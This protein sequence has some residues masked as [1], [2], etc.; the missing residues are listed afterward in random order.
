MHKC[1]AQGGTCRACGWVNTSKHVHCTCLI[2]HLVRRM[3][4]PSIHQHCP[5]HC[6]GPSCRDGNLAG[7]PGSPLTIDKYTTLCEL[8]IGTHPQPPPV[9]EAL[10]PSEGL[11][12]E[13]TITGTQEQSLELSSRTNNHSDSS[14]TLSV[15]VHS[16]ATYE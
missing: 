13:Q 12:R 16:H 2:W 3:M 8:F 1:T 10:Q 5:R 9:A 6:R 7:S 14:L 15:T 11:T 4:L